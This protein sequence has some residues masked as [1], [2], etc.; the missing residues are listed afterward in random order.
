MS[1]LQGLS[2]A[3]PRATDRAWAAVA[4]SRVALANGK[5]QDARHGADLAVELQP[6]SPMRRWRKASCSAASATR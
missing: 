6:F 1:K 4:W 3:A 5:V 2:S